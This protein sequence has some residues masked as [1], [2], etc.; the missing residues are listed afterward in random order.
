[1]AI[2]CRVLKFSTDCEAVF[3]E[4]PLDHNAA[5]TDEPIDHVGLRTG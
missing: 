3:P 1:M 4:G 2:M 5:F